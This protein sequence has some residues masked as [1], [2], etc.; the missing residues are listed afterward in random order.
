M[1]V[2]LGGQHDNK[3]RALVT[4]TVF[5]VFAESHVIQARTRRPLR[6]CVLSV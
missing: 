5:K 2:L 4:V 1:P 6:E 3:L